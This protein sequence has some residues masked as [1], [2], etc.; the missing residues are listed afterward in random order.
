MYG[1][2][3]RGAITNLCGP[4]NPAAGIHGRGTGRP[5]P[6]LTDGCML[7][8]FQRKPRPWESHPVTHPL[9]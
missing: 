4:D 2:G 1:H 6:K 8:P 7:L 9:A 5:A 3:P